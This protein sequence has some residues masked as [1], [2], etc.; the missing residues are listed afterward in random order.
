MDTSENRTASRERLIT[1]LSHKQPDHIPIDFGGTP[2]TGM[3]VS[4]VVA[5]RDHFGL[6]K[7]PVHV[8]EP[9]QMLGT[10]EEDLMA[11]MGLDVIG[12]FARN[13]MFGFPADEWKTWQFNRLE[14]LVPKDF[15]TTVDAEGNTLIY[16][17]G[18]MTV[19]P[20]GRMPQGGYF[21]D[22]IV[23]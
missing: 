23:R 13:T 15:N 10:L 16:P 18:D 11:A 19:P 20:S 5:L 21:F 9:F 17:E 22:C 7:R 14:V 6:K 8:H 1:T 2:T 3:H 4:C 12:T